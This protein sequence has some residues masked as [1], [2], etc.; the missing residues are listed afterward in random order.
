[1]FTFQSTRK[2]HTSSAL[3]IQMTGSHWGT[4]NLVRMYNMQIH[5][6]KCSFC[7]YVQQSCG[8]FQRLSPSPFQSHCSTHS[9]PQL[10]GKPEPPNASSALASVIRVNVSLAL[11]RK[12]TPTRL[13]SP[14][15]QCQSMWHCISDWT[16]S[17][18][19]VYPIILYSGR[20]ISSS[21]QCDILSSKDW[22]QAGKT[23]I[24]QTTL[25]WCQYVMSW[26]YYM[27]SWIACGSFKATVNEFQQPLSH[28]KVTNSWIYVWSHISRQSTK[29]M[30]NYNINAIVSL[31]YFSNIQMTHTLFKCKM[32]KAFNSHLSNCNLL[33]L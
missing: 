27:T 9:D 18:C 29:W 25:I 5:H 13:K 28:M 4:L 24:Q 17:Q 8:P 16:P 31:M 12:S 1:M 30:G 21:A 22:I 10:L 7:A 3:Q 20:D 26:V 6:F 33:W 2:P 11:E 19:S 23:W 14:T 15:S 32:L